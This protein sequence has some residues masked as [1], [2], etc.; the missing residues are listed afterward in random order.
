[1]PGKGE[2][3]DFG[4]VMELN[5]DGLI[6]L[7]SIERFCRYNTSATARQIPRTSGSGH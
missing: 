4:E 2:Q 7:A 5:D 3:M 6:I 1:M